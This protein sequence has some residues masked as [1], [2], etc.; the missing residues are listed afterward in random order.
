MEVPIEPNEFFFDLELNSPFDPLR[1]ADLSK[2]NETI[3]VLDA[4]WLGAEA[5]GRAVQDC[6]LER[7]SSCRTGPPVV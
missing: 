2:H 6:T 1:I 3:P 7:L 5:G 4:T